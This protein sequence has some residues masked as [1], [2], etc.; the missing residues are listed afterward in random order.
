VKISNHVPL[1]ERIRENAMYRHR[2]R[3]AS[4]VW[5]KRTC[6][7][8]CVL[9]TQVFGQSL[10]A[11]EP[12]DTRMA[13]CGPDEVVITV[14]YDNYTDSEK[15]QAQWGFACVVQGL[16]KT[17]LFDTG[18]NGEV[19]IANLREL[20][21]D[22]TKIDAVVLSHAH[23]DHTGGLEAFAKVRSDVPLYVSTGFDGTFIKQTK[24]MKLRPAVA[25]QSATICPGALT[26]GT[27]GRG[28]IEEHALC[29]KTPAGWVLITG[30]AHPGVE[31]LAAKAAELVGSP[32]H[33][34]V[35]GFHMIMQSPKQIERVINRLRELGVERVAPCHCTGDTARKAFRQRYGGSCT[36]AH[37]G[38]VFRLTPEV[39]NAT[40]ATRDP[41]VGAKTPRDQGT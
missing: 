38:S 8:V 16:D 37:V 17:I 12:R 23:G 27:L 28:A 4:S 34:I 41:D 33:L 30:C 9:S 11:D 29:V 3:F 14:A 36:L 39:K 15:L 20:G 5:I 22:P 2:P 26:T 32:P 40:A 31:N 1:R 7:V 21:L 10:L 18:G 25:G 6:L 13:P 24:A 19:L 35:G